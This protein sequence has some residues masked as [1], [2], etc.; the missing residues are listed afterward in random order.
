MIA[1]PPP[2]GTIAPGAVPLA[3]GR[4][5]ESGVNIAWL[6]LLAVISR[7]LFT[8]FHFVGGEPGLRIFE[9]LATIALP[10]LLFCV[11][12]WCFS[13]LTDGKGRFSDIYVTCCVSLLPLI[14]TLPLAAILSNMLTLD[15]TGI[16][17]FITTIG[18]IWFA[19]SLFCGILVTHDYS[20]GKTVLTLV[21]TVLGMV[22]ILFLTIL[23]LNLISQIIGFI[24][25]LGVE[26][27]AR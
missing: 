19:F 1:F 17:Q 14:L 26:I 2:A 12:N 8:S 4:I 9:A 3:L 24:R 16:Y 27:S 5:T 10:L 25:N 20:F 13:T 7:Q 18:M 15:E 23:F 21:L 6:R 11:S 22:I